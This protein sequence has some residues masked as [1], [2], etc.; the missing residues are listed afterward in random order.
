MEKKQAFLYLFFSFFFSVTALFAQ[1][2]ITIK[3]RLIDSVSNSQIRDAA[4]ALYHNDSLIVSHMVNDNGLFDFIFSSKGNAGK[5]SIKLSHLNYVSRSFSIGNAKVDVDL[6][7]VRL[8]Q[9]TINLSQVNIVSGNSP[10]VLKKNRDTLEADFSNHSFKRYVMTEDALE[11]IPGVKIIGSRFFFNGEEISDIKVGEKNFVFDNRFLMQNLPGFTIGKVQIIDKVDQS[12]K[13]AKRVNIMLKKDDKYAYIFNSILARG[14][15]SSEWGT[16]TAARI[17]SLF[18]I[19]IRVQSNNIN[20]SSSDAWDLRST[21]NITDIPGLNKAKNLELSGL[22][23]FS[24]K[25]TLTF[26]YTDDIQSSINEQNSTIIDLTS[27][28]QSN[29]NVISDRTNKSNI[30][31][32]SLRSKVDSITELSFS[33][34]S[35]FSRNNNSDN[36]SYLNHANNNIDSTYLNTNKSFSGERVGFVFALNKQKKISKADFYG[37]ELRVGGD[38]GENNDKISNGKI[39]SLANRKAKKQYL[40]LDYKI[41]FYVNKISS[42][43]A[44]VKSDANYYSSKDDQISSYASIRTNQNNF[45]LRYSLNKERTVF[46]IEAKALNYFLKFNGEK[47]YNILTFTSNASYDHSFKNENKIYLSFTN[48]Y[49]FPSITQ[50]TGIADFGQQQLLNIQPNSELKPEHQLNLNFKYNYKRLMDLDLGILYVINKIENILVNSIDQAPIIKYL[51]SNSAKS[52]YTTVGLNKY[53]LG[54]KVFFSNSLGGNYN[55]SNFSLSDK[56]ASNSSVYLFYNQ[57]FRYD[58]RKKIKLEYL[59]NMY[60]LYYLGNISQRSFTISNKLNVAYDINEVFQIA[61]DSQV[62]NTTTSIK[63]NNGSKLFNVS[64]NRKFL[65]NRN[66]IVFSKVNNIFN[67]KTQQ[68]LFADVNRLQYS[69]SSN[70]GRFFLF[71]ISYKLSTFK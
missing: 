31:N 51:N 17:D 66:L 2:S 20:Q 34:I 63:V 39:D 6:G 22:Y 59:L 4:V 21:N 35:S 41:N 42:F 67:N 29:L 52:I 28:D 44:S 47:F 45:G 62:S 25:T 19:G 61:L 68:T 23:E 8:S 71:G 32:L 54:N 43:Q 30:I 70:I 26:K 55:I 56:L 69:Y 38:Q 15:K 58:Y 13:H 48:D 46:L 36:A 60:Q 24:K 7:I 16:L 5:Y 57:K 11:I 3:G 33:N 50:L 10:A 40:E 65:K 27:Q 12:G 14:N 53:F 9:R 37:L 18:Q 1:K 49:N 64:L